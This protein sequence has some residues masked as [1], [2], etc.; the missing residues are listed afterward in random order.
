MTRDMAAI[1]KHSWRKGSRGWRGRFARSGLERKGRDSPLG[2]FAVGRLRAPVIS[3]FKVHSTLSRKQG[4]LG[5][6]C[7]YL[8]R[9][10]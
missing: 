7:E 9:G 8:V 5:G 10:L 3:R 1:I 2:V 4:S 6:E